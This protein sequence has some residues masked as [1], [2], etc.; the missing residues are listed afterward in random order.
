[1]RAGDRKHH[2]FILSLAQP[3]PKV[4]TLSPAP[5]CAS[6]NASSFRCIFQRIGLQKRS[7]RTL[8]ARGKL[9]FT[10]A[11]IHMR[12]P[13][14]LFSAIQSIRLPSTLPSAAPSSLSKINGGGCNLLAVASSRAARGGKRRS[15]SIRHIWF[16]EPRAARG[17]FSANF[18]MSKVA[19]GYFCSRN[20]LRLSRLF[21]TISSQAL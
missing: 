4:I 14:N 5:E 20:S 9:I 8:H 17:G 3:C 15:G 16:P 13:I 7:Y 19:L 18:S 6:T 12:P 21:L 1:M 10:V 2:Q 11:F